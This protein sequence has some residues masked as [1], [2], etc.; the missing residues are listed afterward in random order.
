[1][2][3]HLVLKDLRRDLTSAWQPL[4]LCLIPLIATGLMAISFGPREG[5]D[6]YV[7]EIRIALLDLDEGLVSG[8]LGSFA[9]QSDVNS[10]IRVI[11]VESEKEGLRILENREASA[12]MILPE[13]FSTDLING[14]TTSIKVYENPAELMLPRAVV[15]GSEIVAAFLSIAAELIGE[16]M[17]ELDQII[18]TEDWPEEG[19]LSEFVIQ[20]TRQIRSLEHALFPP[21]VNYSKVAAH[22]YIPSASRKVNP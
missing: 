21:I 20:T 9:G 7:P 3:L 18:E 8:F 2:I 4:L 5:N 14:A 22:E 6:E 16:P 1:M 11:N 13:N 19:M 12:F 17:R 10:T 15:Q